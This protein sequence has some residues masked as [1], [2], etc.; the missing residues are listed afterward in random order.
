ML[1]KWSG[2]PLAAGFALFIPQFFTPQPVRVAHGLLVIVGC[3]VLAW[4]MLSRAPGKVTE[5][6]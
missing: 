5:R 4:S 3:V 2:I 1:D 6:H